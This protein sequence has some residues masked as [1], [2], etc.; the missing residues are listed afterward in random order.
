MTTCFLDGY[1]DGAVVQMEVP[2][3]CH[4]LTVVNTAVQLAIVIETKSNVSLTL[5]SRRIWTENALLF[6][7]HGSQTQRQTEEECLTLSDNLHQIPLSASLGI[8]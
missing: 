7:P 5:L 2:E 6:P 1:C 3:R 8:C 4:R